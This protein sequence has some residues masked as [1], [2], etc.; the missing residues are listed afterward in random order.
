M[1]NIYDENGVN[2]AEA[3]RE[4]G[5]VTRTIHILSYAADPLLREQVH[6]GCERSENW[7]SF[8]E[9]IFFGKGGRIETNNPMRREEIGLAMAIVQNAIVF[10]NV[11]RHGS[12]LLKRPSATPVVWHHVMLLG[13]Y[14]IKKR[15]STSKFGPET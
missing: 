9:A 3:L 10:H 4:L 15:G 8:Q 1:W 12:R 2:I 14:R 5:K 13:R 11:W 7:N 6:R